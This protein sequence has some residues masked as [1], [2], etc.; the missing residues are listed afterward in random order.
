MNPIVI[1]Q[2]DDTYALGAEINILLETSLDLTGFQAAF[3]LGNY[4]QK[5]NDISSKK[6]SIK[7]PRK[8]T[9]NL[10]VGPCTG[11]LKIYDKNGFA[12][13]IVRDIKFLILA[14]VVKNDE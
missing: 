2:G 13:T 4:Y 14:E 12:K 10:K 8:D 1:T 11:A 6:I 5:F 7:I 3:Q 9:K